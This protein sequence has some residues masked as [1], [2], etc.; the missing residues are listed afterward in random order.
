M[1]DQHESQRVIDGGGETPAPDRWAWRLQ[2]YPLAIIFALALAVVLGAVATA[3][4]SA[5]AESLGGDYPA[6]YGAGE[7]ASAGDWDDLYDLD[8]QAEA[9][10]GLHPVSDGAVARFY[11]YPP[12]VAA[13]YQPFAGLDYHWSYLLHTM[14]MA[15]LL[16]SAV[17]LVRPMI[18]RLRGHVAL[19]VAAAL[20]FWPMFRAVTGG[21]NTALTVFLIAA[22]WR[23]VHEDQQLG[24]GLVLAGLLY[25]PQFA[26]PMIGLFLLGRYWRVVIGATA[27]ALVFYASGAVLQGW[28]WGFNWVEAA[29]DFGRV[30]AELNGH[31]SIS[32]IGMAENLF[33]VGMSAALAVAWLLAGATAVF[34][35]WLWWRSERSDL[36]G[37]MAITMP[38][39]LLLSPHAMSHDG[40]VVVLSVAVVVGVWGWR[41][42]VPWIA[43]IWA[44][45]ATQMMIRQ[46]GF[47][48]GF[49]MLF[50]VLGGA[51][52]L[53]RRPD[54]RPPWSR[55]LPG[56]EAQS[57]RV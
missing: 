7:I 36:S 2:F 46:L 13:V 39:I 20:L 8:R 22:A 25:K 11:A 5:P 53:L 9:Q 51:W 27:G 29:A 12:Q 31:S 33:G 35:A 30:D 52:L 16:W 50:V 40:A 43:I 6:F 37:L 4:S 1:T 57:V 49:F 23:L 15:L 54:R 38:G 34:L 19:A 21:S 3:D 14:I 17:L 32:L 44:L 47:S 18:P 48:P 28:N 26:V 55:L 10:A 42:C 24:A 56:T 45:G 41:D